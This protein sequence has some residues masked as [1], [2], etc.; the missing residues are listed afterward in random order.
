MGTMSV[1]VLAGPLPAAEQ[2]TAP[3][4]IAQE[5]AEVENR[6]RTDATRGGFMI[7]F[8]D[9]QRHQQRLAGDDPDIPACLGDVGFRLLIAGRLEYAGPAA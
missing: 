9:A 8:D 2:G 6:D 4:A 7:S 3:P 5:A 1:C